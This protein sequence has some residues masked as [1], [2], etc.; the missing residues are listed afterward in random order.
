M[1]K[2][3]KLILKSGPEMGMEF[4]LEK[5]EIFLGRDVNNDIVINDPEVSRRHARFSRQGEDYIYEDLG[6][7]NGSFVLGQRIDSPTFLPTGTVI[8]IGE[9][10]MLA[11]EVDIIDPSATMVM[12]RRAAQTPVAA[13]T[14]PP[15][16][17][18]QA[19]PPYVQP[20][21]VQQVP[22]PPVAITPPPITTQN[23]TPTKKPSKGVVILLIVLGIIL[24][25]CVIPWLIV[26]LTDSYCSL[27]PGFFN[28]IQAGTC[29]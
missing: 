22:Q 9:R 29:L 24:V 4:P 2:T 7:T 27:F 17:I 11:Y 8:T 15:T 1:T 19:P 16:P 20:P 25:F 6:S 14:P 3:Y 13:Q 26:E 12:P 28:A 18:V 5:E 10:V 23:S 21:A